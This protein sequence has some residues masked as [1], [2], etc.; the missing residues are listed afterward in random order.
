ML[1]TG[2]PRFSHRQT[3]CVVLLF[4]AF[5]ACAGNTALLP[6][7]RDEARFAQATVQML[8]T[9]DFINIKF[10]AEARNKKPVGIHWLQA[11]SVATFSSA[12]AREIWA[13]RL[14]SLISVVLAT[15]LTY[16]TAT[17]LFGT[18]TG[19]I[20]ALLLSAAPLVAGEAT[21][22]KTDATLLA[23]VSAAQ[24]TFI[25][26]YADLRKSR[27]TM[28]VWPV[29]FW[30]AI[31]F[32]ILIKGPIVPL[33]IGLTALGMFFSNRRLAWQAAYRPIVG[34]LIIVA[35]VAPWAIM[36][37][38]KTNGQFFADAIG[39]DLV[40]K[41][42]SGQESHG[43]PPGYHLALLPAL[44]WPAIA[45]LPLGIFHAVRTRRAW[46][47]R[48][49][50]A[51]IV[52]AWIVFEISATKL[53]H[54]TLPLYPALAILSARA[55][56]LALSQRRA[57]LRKTGAV[58][59]ALVGVGFGALILGLSKTYGQSTGAIMG[60]A[61]VIGLASAIAGYFFWRG[62]MA[63]GVGA[64][65]FTST[66]LATSLLWGVLPNL[67]KLNISERV[68]DRLIETGYHP[69]KNGAEE[70]ALAGYREPSAIFLLGT[71]TVLTDGNGAAQHL[72]E[73]PSAAVI[74]EMDE[75]R[76]FQSSA[77]LLN[78]NISTLDVVAGVNY[79]NG[80]EI[81]LSIYARNP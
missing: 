22:A 33:I 30:L 44:F 80:E 63:R 49:L 78:L 34:I 55:L 14:P 21:I 7:D 70:I 38:L 57:W 71:K 15:Y 45:L 66:L 65:I 29:A 40:G 24:A 41:I 3:L 72:S 77:Q 56:S 42:G 43:G 76:A 13:Y 28:W 32:G 12:D 48:V 46:T 19:L 79:S 35:L 2:A 69:L 25:K 8:E 31:G 26:I 53:P 73:N 1:P 6:L 18:Q 20:A 17:I 4:S 81:S 16:V 67:E 39:G 62:H 54:Y 75:D 11:A 52:P 68:S 37:G 74:V 27:P 47:S 60:L 61:G 36:I 51:W 50:L 59:F 5:V 58:I 9:G 23:C 64:S 10:Q